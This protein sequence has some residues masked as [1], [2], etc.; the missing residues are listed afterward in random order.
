M[1]TA[2]ILFTIFV[3]ISLIYHL[4]FIFR[5]DYDYGAIDFLA[6]LCDIVMAILSLAFLWGVAYGN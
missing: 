3:A 5:K 6:L 4:S 2:T 1:L